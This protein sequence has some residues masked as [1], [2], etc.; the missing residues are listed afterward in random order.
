[1]L[2]EL[3]E[4]PV[5]EGVFVRPD[6]A[7]FFAATASPSEGGYHLV[8]VKY[9]PRKGEKMR[10]LKVRRHTLVLETY[11]GP[12]NGR[13]ALHGRLGPSVDTVENLRWGTAKENAADAM[14]DG[15]VARGAKHGQAKITLAQAME[16]YRRYNA[17]ESATPLGREFGLTAMSVCDLGA[18]RT[19]AWM[20]DDQPANG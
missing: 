18:R 5:Y 4:H 13:M 9:A 10:D 3:R 6:G 2:M 12:A 7:V 19:W 15:A 17:G 16:I 14:R 20:H 11:A 8:H 1:M